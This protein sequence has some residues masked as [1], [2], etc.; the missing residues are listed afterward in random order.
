MT[1]GNYILLMLSVVV[2]IWLV[3]SYFGH[4][5][6]ILSGSILGMVSLAIV[7]HMGISMGINAVTCLMCGIFGIPGFFTLF[8]LK[9]L[10]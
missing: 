3:V 4:I 5:W 1:V 10:I 7:N 6:K 2:V 9:A 8:L